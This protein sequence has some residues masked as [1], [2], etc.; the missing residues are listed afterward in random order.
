MPPASSSRA[1]SDVAPDSA[2][3]TPDAAAAVL[4]SYPTAL[5]AHD[6]ARQAV[7]WEPETS[8]ASVARRLRDTTI[9]AFTV[10]TPGRIEGAAGS[11]YI[12]VP[13]TLDLATP[14][15]QRLH[16]VATLRRAVVDGATAAERH[17]RIMR[18]EWNPQAQH[19]QR[20]SDSTVHR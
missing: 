13:V 14:D 19:P 17:W 5:R 9:A 18:L 16:G 15:P 3:G 1:D 4:R 2:Q 12:E 10:G 6:G 11:R 7:E 8:E 20:M